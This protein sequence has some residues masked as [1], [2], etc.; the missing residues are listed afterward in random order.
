MTTTKPIT[1]E[2]LAAL[3]AYAAKHGDSWKNFLNADWMRARAEPE[4]HRLRNTHGPRWLATFKL[5]G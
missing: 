3:K 1:P 5:E 4:L 2:E